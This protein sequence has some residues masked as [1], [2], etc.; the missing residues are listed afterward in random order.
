MKRLTSLFS[1]C[2]VFIIHCTLF[3]AY[4]SLATAQERSIVPLADPYI[5][6]DGDTYYAYGTHD[7][8]G[9]ELWTSKDLLGWTKQDKLALSKENTTEQQWFWAPEVYQKNGQYYM[10][11]SAN[12]HLFVATASSPKGP[13][14]QVGGYMMESLIGDEK[15][16]DSSVFFDDD[17]T[18]YCFFVRFTDG[19]C[20]W[21]CQLADDLVTPVEGTLRKCI[22]VTQGWEN[23]LGRVNEGPFIW[24]Q[25]N[26]YYLTYSGN[27]YRSPDHAVGYAMS[28][29]LS[30]TGGSTPSW[31]KY[32]NNPIVRRVEDLVGCGHHSLFTDKEGRLRIVFHAHH[33][34][35][36]VAPRRMYIGT[37]EFRGNALRMTDEPVLRPTTPQKAAAID[38]ESRLPETQA[39]TRIYDLGGHNHLSLVQGLNILKYGDGNVAKVMRR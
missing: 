37:M 27:D 38:D 1:Y 10:Y 2:T 4:C 26:I 5:L 39:P 17:G 32:A 11:F 7:A 29:S 36:V 8:N 21:M 31:T 25:N 3:I 12:E 15:C 16:I 6:L 35:T 14:K 19:N 34:E 13:F 18:A 30:T 33:S 23:L 22:N 28:R 20:I 24:K 9:I